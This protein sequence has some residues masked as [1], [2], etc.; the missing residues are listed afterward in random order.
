MWRRTGRR[1]QRHRL[2][3]RRTEEENKEYISAE[4][5]REKK[6]KGQ[7][8]CGEV[9]ESEHVTT[10]Y[11]LLLFCFVI[12]LN[13]LRKSDVEH[14]GRTSLFGDKESQTETLEEKQGGEEQVLIM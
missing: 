3:R 13:M 2:V 9:N 7:F 6:I 4:K 14:E 11:G 5:N 1:K 8:W 12:V 10:C